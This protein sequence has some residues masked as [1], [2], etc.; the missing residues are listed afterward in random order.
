MYFRLERG[1][2]EGGNSICQAGTG[3]Q[4][5]SFTTTF[6]FQVGNTPV[7]LDTWGTST[8]VGGIV[9]YYVITN[10]NSPGTGSQVSII[11]VGTDGSTAGFTDDSLYFNATSG[12]PNILNYSVSVTDGVVSFLANTIA[13]DA[14]ATVTL[15]KFPVYL[16]QS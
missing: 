7:L 9:N 14:V 13:T 1:A 4:S 16:V 5:N 12:T 8:I 11:N 3:S 6:T 2:A 10:T 15:I